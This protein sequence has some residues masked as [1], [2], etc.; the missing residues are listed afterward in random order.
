[1]GY[2]FVL[3]VLSISFG[4]VSICFF[5]RVQCVNKCKLSS[6]RPQ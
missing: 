6:V 2:S 1:M 5:I 4:S 3:L